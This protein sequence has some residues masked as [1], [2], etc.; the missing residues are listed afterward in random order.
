VDLPANVWDGI[1]SEVG[2]RGDSE[3]G[4]AESA[5]FRLDIERRQTEDVN[6]T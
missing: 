1:G 4:T 5:H 3:G 2:R 6:V